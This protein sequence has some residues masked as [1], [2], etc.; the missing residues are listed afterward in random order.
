[1][2]S[3]Q[4][5]LQTPALL[6]WSVCERDVNRSPHN[7]AASL[8]AKIMDVMASLPRDTMAKACRKFCH[9]IEAVVEAGGDFFE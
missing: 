4:P 9:R 7:T 5:R 3:Q 6:L 8:K 2:A 1:M